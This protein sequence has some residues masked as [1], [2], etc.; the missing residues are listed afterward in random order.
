[1]D[2]A[3]GQRHQQMCESGGHGNRDDGAVRWASGQR[4]PREKETGLRLGIRRG[5]PFGHAA[6]ARAEP[7]FGPA[8]RRLLGKAAI[9]PQERGDGEERDQRHRQPRALRERRKSRQ[10]RPIGGPARHHPVV[11]EIRRTK[12]E[13]GARRASR[14][15]CA[16]P[17]FR[18]RPGTTARDEPAIEPATAPATQSC[19]AVFRTAGASS[20]AVTAATTSELCTVL[21]TRR[22]PRSPTIRRQTPRAARML[23]KPKRPAITTLVAWPAIS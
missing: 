21:E 12:I 19:T 20:S 15:R 23:K 13:V 5:Q 14:P 1:M 10:Q 4:L 2:A 3:R 18:S 8:G 9:V 7:R 22:N 17:R 16:R 6:N 11:W